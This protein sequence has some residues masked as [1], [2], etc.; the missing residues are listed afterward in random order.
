MSAV[1]SQDTSAAPK[2]QRDLTPLFLVGPSTLLFFALV[3]SLIHI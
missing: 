1:T 2:G 3:L